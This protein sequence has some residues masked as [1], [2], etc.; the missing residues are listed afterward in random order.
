M[1]L[2]LFNFN[3]I[4]TVS[5]LLWA[6]ISGKG[7]MSGYFF[8][9]LFQ[10]LATLIMHFEAF[11]RGFKLKGFV[12]YWAMVLLFFVLA[13]QVKLNTFLFMALP[14]LIALYNCYLYYWFYKQ[15]TAQ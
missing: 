2:M 13:N 8:L 3:L 1:R 14:M 11:S 12:I 9:G 10:L 6:L 5:C 7:A 4:A 15:K